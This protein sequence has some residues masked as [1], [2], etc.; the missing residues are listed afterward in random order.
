MKKNLILL[1]LLTL[2]IS[3]GAQ[4]MVT[5]TGTVK[6]DLKTYKKI[7]F[8][9]KSG[10]P[11]SVEMTKNTFTYSFP[12]KR[13]LML[14]MHTEFQKATAGFVAPSGILIDRPGKIA[15]DDVAPSMVDVM[16]KTSGAPATKEFLTLK[17]DLNAKVEML[18]SKMDA[19][20]GIGKDMD[21]SSSRFADRQKE[22]TSLCQKMI[23]DYLKSYI[24][25]R[26]DSY[27]A[28]REVNQQANFLTPDQLSKLLAMFSPKLQQL[29]EGVGIADFI[30]GTKLSGEGNIVEN[31][32][33]PTPQNQ[34][35][36]LND[37]KGKYVMI[38]F[39]A[40]WCSP[41]KASFPHMK[42]LYS[43]YK[44]DKFEL[45]SIS[46]DERK[47]AWLRELKNQQ[48]P[49]LQSLDTSN[50]SSRIFAVEGVPTVFLLDPKGKIIA[51][52]LG[53]VASE[54][55]PVEKKLQEVFGK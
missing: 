43:K 1:L 5:I 41:C 24:A 20:Y 26:P 50:V 3:A 21:R 53:F 6:G 11:D 34:P 29:G 36:S 46:I 15:I 27:V 52:Q 38:D 37:L 10:N 31:F 44:S 22:Y 18:W 49:W 28:L 17:K 23:G 9:V 14:Y 12:F 25:Q 2:Y 32:T 40:S 30:R 39:W 7:Y 8:R 35:I 42:E 16:I 48:L 13:P 33:L 54:V 19:K 47:D 55:G 45:Y 51:K 4:N